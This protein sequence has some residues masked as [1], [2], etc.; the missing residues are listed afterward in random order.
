MLHAIRSRNRA[1]EIG[2]PFFPGSTKGG[3]VFIPETGLT[4]PAEP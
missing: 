2:F 1:K 4:R 3:S